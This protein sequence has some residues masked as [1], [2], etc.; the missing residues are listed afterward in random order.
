MLF[1]NKVKMIKNFISLEWKQFLRSSNFQKSLIIKI[2]MGIGIFFL[3]LYALG[4]G[5]GLYFGLEDLFPDKNPW[6]L[7]NNYI[8]FWF[9][10]EIVL[11]YLIQKMPVLSIKPLLILPINRNKIIHYGLIKLLLSIFNFIPVFILIPFSVVLLIKGENPL[12]VFAWFLGIIAFSYS[13]N[14][15]TFL[16]NK[17]NVVFYSVL[18][19]LI[20]LIALEYFDVFKLSHFAGQAFNYF[21]TIPYLVFIPLVL[22]FVSY[23]MSFKF[24]KKHLNLDTI[25][26][27]HKEVT[28]TDLSWVNRFGTMA[29]FLKNDIK[30]IWR[31]V[32]PRKTVLSAF[33]FLFYALYF[34]KMK[35]GMDSPAM[36][37]FAMMFVTGGFA[38]TFG[39]FVPSWDS[40]YYQLLM[41]QNIRYKTYLESKW[42]LMGFVVIVSFVL[43]TPY[44]YFGWEVYA[45]LVAGAFFNLGINSY[46]VLFGGVLNRMP[47]KL[48]EKAK[49][50]GNTQGFSMTNF[51]IAL[52]KI[53]LPILMFAIPNH[54]WGFNAGISTIIGVSLIG[55]I[56]KNYFLTQIEKI[57]Q[58]NKYK[59]IA[60]FNEKK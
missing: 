22:L 34:I 20:S 30:L 3:L 10:A 14:F 45:L 23:Q 31:N 43:A 11:R 37:A 5:V 19:L 27:Q 48:N 12:N 28:T 35:K 40:E 46:L 54:F 59:T 32:R 4:I 49:A 13:L 33:I 52:P 26:S 18:T 1:Q 17:S 29:P 44:I 50:F 21:R 6:V 16:L 57:Y 41:S 15:I 56:F 8:I 24:M 2:F 39:Q 25:T 60:A 36:L 9:L 51:L 7:V 55:I 38:M 58:K 47:L 42:Y 53:L